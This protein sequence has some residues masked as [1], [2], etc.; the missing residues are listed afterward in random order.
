MYL[1]RTYKYDTVFVTHIRHLGMQKTAMDACDLRE[2]E[3]HP[4]IAGASSL[5]I[6]KYT[7]FFSSFNGRHGIN[8]YICLL[9]IKNYEK[10]AQSRQGNSS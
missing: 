10:K 4:H 6:N 2:Y 9:E 5:F 1:N 8:T 3:Y 7:H